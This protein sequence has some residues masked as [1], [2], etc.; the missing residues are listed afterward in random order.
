VVVLL[1]RLEML[2]QILDAGTEKGNLHLRG[3]GV[4]LMELVTLDDVFSF[5][6]I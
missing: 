5:L 6:R 3:T 2:R 4:P 1:V